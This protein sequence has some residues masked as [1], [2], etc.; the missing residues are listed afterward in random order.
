MNFHFLDEKINNQKNYRILAKYLIENNINVIEFFEGLDIL[1]EENEGI[2]SKGGKA[3]DSWWGKL[4]NWW[5]G[6]RGNPYDVESVI[7]L[8]DKAENF[9][10]NTPGAQ[11]QY[12]KELF[13]L[14]KTISGLK[15]EESPDGS[16][17]GTMK[18]VTP[19]EKTSGVS[20]VGS[21]FAPDQSS[22]YRT[23]SIKNIKIN[24]KPK[25]VK[26]GV[27][28]VGDQYSIGELPHNISFTYSSS[29]PVPSDW[30]GIS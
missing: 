17:R 29:D 14:S 4:R 3:V 24:K 25:K 2:F 11:E 20:S 9:L 8:L 12:K 27:S 28:K 1:K 15:G 10:K 5:S 21:E 18:I 26:G 7:K 30:K 6:F 22:Q 13:H 19:P 23:D 16:F